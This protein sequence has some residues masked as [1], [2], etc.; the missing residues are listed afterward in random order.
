MDKDIFT[1]AEELHS[2]GT[3]LLT[4]TGLKKLLEKTGKVEIGGSYLY[5]LLTH[6]DIDIGIISPKAVKEIFGD[7]VGEL[8]KIPAVLKVKTSDR[9]THARNDDATRPKGFWIGLTILFEKTS[10]N[11]DIWY[12]K[13]EWYKDRSAELFRALSTI[14]EKQRSAILTIKSELREKGVH[15][16]GQRFQSVDVYDAVLYKDI[17][18]AEGMNVQK[19]NKQILKK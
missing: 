3:R 17:Y 4:E 12:Q 7:L 5:N 19:S 2:Q 6:S 18:T 11:I 9:V 10:W 1:I 16:V 8:A 14:T 13:P 15:G